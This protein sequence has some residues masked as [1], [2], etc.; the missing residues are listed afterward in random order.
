MSEARIIDGKA[1][2]ASVQERVA[3]AVSELRMKHGFVPGLAVVLVG[4]DPASRVYVRNKG[5]RTTEAGMKSFEYLLPAD[6]T[7]KALLDRIRLLNESPEVHGILVQLPLPA[8]IDPERVLFAIDPAKDVDG[9]HPLNVG[10]LWT[11][12]DPL[13]D[14]LL[15]P[16]TPRGCLLLIEEVLGRAGIAGRSQQNGAAGRQRRR[17]APR[18]PHAHAVSSSTGNSATEAVCRARHSSSRSSSAAS[19]RASTAAASS[20]A[21]MAPA[22]PIANVPTGTPPGICTMESRLS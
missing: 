19:D 18:G 14:D 8:H 1:L 15:V 3:A 22:R 17:L 9:F 5:R 4:D 7:E 2:A 6:T 16:C 10:R 11:A 12:R 13:A 21:L 20:A